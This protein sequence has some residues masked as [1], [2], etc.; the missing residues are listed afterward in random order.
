MSKALSKKRSTTLTKTT[1]PP[2]MDFFRQFPFKDGA[3]SNTIEFWDSIPKFVVSP[4]EQNRR[5]TKEGLLQ[6]HSHQFVYKPT[7]GDVKSQEYNC[8]V[9]IKPAQIKDSDGKYRH[10]FPSTDEELVEEVL[11]YIFIEQQHGTHSAVALESLV[12]YTLY[13]VDKELRKRNKTRSFAEI[14]RSIDILADTKYDVM[15]EGLPDSYQFK[16][17]ILADVITRSRD[18][19]FSDPKTLSVARFPILFSRSINNVEYRFISFDTLLDLKNPV[20]RFLHRRMSH[21]FT[22]ADMMR[23]YKIDFV[24]IQRDSARLDS[25]RPTRNYK[26]VEEAWQELAEKNIIRDFDPAKDSCIEKV[27]NKVMNIYYTVYITSEFKNVIVESNIRHKN[28][29]DTLKQ[30]GR[31]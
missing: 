25:P 5:R 30:I 1:Q 22:N 23:P 29:S 21:E 10:Y 26:K 31:R 8:T 15:S 13:M 14:K 9:T 4:A 20:A 24:T 7:Y 19:H 6:P 27:G 2:Q 17:S 16:G 12:K 3:F 11:R 18:Q 28:A